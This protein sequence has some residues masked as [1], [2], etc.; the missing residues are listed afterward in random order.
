MRNVQG[1]VFMWTE[2]SSDIFCISVPLSDNNV[3]TE[4]DYTHK[5]HHGKPSWNY[6]TVWIDRAQIFIPSKRVEYNHVID[7]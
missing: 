1:I 4:V 3:K 5:F 2:T 6:P 7:T